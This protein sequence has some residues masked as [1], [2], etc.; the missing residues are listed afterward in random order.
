MAKPKAPT[1]AEITRRL[2]TIKLMIVGLKDAMPRLASELRREACESI[3][4]LIEDVAR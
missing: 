1:P 3:D 2:L 4:D